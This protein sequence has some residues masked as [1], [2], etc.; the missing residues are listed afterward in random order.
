MDTCV[1]YTFWLWYAKHFNYILLVRILLQDHYSLQGKLKDVIFFQAV[2]EHPQ[3][4]LE[5]Y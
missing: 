4:Q 3:L 2:K 5:F 1:V